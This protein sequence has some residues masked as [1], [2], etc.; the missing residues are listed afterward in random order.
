MKR[1]MNA[2]ENVED[3][4]SSISPCC[5]FHLANYWLITIQQ[6]NK[7]TFVVFQAIIAGE[8]NVVSL[9]ASCGHIHSVIHFNAIFI[10][11]DRTSLH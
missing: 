5:L 10:S 4:C 9:M 11:P 1:G 8:L 2:E 3:C 7:Y 6:T